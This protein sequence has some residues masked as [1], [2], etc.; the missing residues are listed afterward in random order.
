[1]DFFLQKKIEFV[2]LDCDCVFKQSG[3]KSTRDGLDYL[4]F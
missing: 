1:M 3:E 4:C 2:C